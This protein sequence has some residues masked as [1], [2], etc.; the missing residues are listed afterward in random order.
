M[1]TRGGGAVQEEAEE[2]RRGEKRL[3]ILKAV[4]QV[5]PAPLQFSFLAPR[6]RYRAERYDCVQEV[7]KEQH[8]SR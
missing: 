8:V 7:I 2:Y 6:V 3:S 1:A 4:A 5:R